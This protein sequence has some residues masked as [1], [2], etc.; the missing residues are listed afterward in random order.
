[1]REA[2]EEFELN[3]EDASRE[4]AEDVLE[5]LGADIDPAAVEAILAQYWVLPKEAA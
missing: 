1:M 4:A 3:R 2:W 5:L